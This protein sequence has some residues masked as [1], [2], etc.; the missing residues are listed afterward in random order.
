MKKT[1][2]N[3]D[4]CGHDEAYTRL[5]SGSS[6]QLTRLHN[7]YRNREEQGHSRPDVMVRNIDLP[8]ADWTLQYDP[9]QDPSLFILRIGRTARAWRSGNAY[10]SISQRKASTSSMYLFAKYYLSNWPSFFDSE[11]LKVVKATVSTVKTL[12]TQNRDFLED[13]IGAS[14][15]FVCT[16]N[17][18]ANSSFC[19]QS[20][21]FARVSRDVLCFNYEK[22]W[23]F[24]STKSHWNLQRISTYHK[25]NAKKNLQENNIRRN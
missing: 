19:F 25:S 21:S 18:K 11:L 20:L 7:K 13:E 23:K 3:V 1:P 5:H 16:K 24:S 17:N 9:Q 10:T 14:I 4:D 8:D 2:S 22:P 6:R 15:A 12:I